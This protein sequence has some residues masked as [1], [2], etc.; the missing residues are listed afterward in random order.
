MEELYDFIEAHAE[1]DF[2]SMWQS[3]PPFY[4]SFIKRGLKNVEIWRRTGERTPHTLD[5]GSQRAKINKILFI[6]LLQ[7]W[8]KE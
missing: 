6:L 4:Q 2:D 5:S 3:T 1:I 8:L 7:K